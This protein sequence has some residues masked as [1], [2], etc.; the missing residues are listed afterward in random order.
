MSANYNISETVEK[1]KMEKQIEATR[2]EELGVRPLIN[3]IGT[4]TTLS[5]SLV[6]PEVRQAMAE[7]AKR[8]VRI[9]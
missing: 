1:N 4:I 5:G 9:D 2:Y 8:Y 6:L 3:C 7:A